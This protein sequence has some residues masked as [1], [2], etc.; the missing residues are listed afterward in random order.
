MTDDGAGLLGRQTAQIAVTAH[1]HLA[2]HALQAHALA[3]F[4][5]VDAGHTVV[6][7]LADFGRHDHAASAAEHLNVLAAALLEQVDHVLE[8]LDMTALVGADGDALGI[9]LQGGGHHLIDRA[10]VAQVNHLGAHALQDAA[11]DV[12]GRIMP[13]KQAGGGDETH[14][15][16]RAIV[17]Q[18]LELGRQVG[19]GK[20]PQ[21][22]NRSRAGALQRRHQ[23]DTGHWNPGSLIDVYV[24]VNI[25]QAAS[26]R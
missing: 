15:V 14:L 11:H 6:L 18:G 22:W 13:V 8:I 17:G 10:V 24:N 4:R 21:R 23:Q 16:R 9:F 1:Q 3:V 20:S 7:Q 2:N 5:A 26:W 12:D 25:T 19:H